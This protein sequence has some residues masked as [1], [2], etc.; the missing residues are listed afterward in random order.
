MDTVYITVTNKNSFD[1]SYTV[2]LGGN[3]SQSDIN[4]AS[5]T[6]SI[7]AKA[8]TVYK[9]TIPSNVTNTG[10]FVFSIDGTDHS[11]TVDVLDGPKIGDTYDV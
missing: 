7:P 9:Y 5:L 8:T 1:G 2:T 3:V 4:N 11:T 6:G 10:F